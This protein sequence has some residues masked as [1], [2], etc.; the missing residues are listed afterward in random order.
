M[1]TVAAAIALAVCLAG[2]GTAQNCC[3]PAV[4]QQGVLGETT[5]LP[6]TLELGF[7]YERLCSYGK[8]DG[9]DS[10]AD[11]DDTKT[12]WKRAT[13][14][15]GYGI[16]PRL[17]VTA[18]VPYLW[19]EKSEIA[20]TSRMRIATTTEGLGDMSLLVRYSPLGRSFVNF[21]ELSLGL[22]VKIPTGAT[23]R[24][25]FGTA[26]LAELQPGTGSWDYIGSVSFYQGFEPVDFVVSATYLMTTAYDGYDFGSYEFGN[27]L[28]YLLT[29]TF[30]LAS[31]IDVSAAL[32]GTKRGKDRRDGERE[33]ATGRHQVWFMP[34]VQVQAIPEMLRLHVY[35]EAPVYQHFNGVQLGSDYNL[36]F[37]ASFLLPL[38]G[39]EDE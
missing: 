27:Q 3:A 16:I 15:V 36:R 11:P 14:T 38:A 31:R 13:L 34:G 6:H 17:G 22:G 32:S 4:P 1:R 24:Q 12:D 33:T 18:I 21:R 25:K 19:K 5:A 7:H 37:T 2:T 28:S 23:D 20:G 35:Y 30:H 9:S 8:Y 10:V 26:L 29:A 39:E